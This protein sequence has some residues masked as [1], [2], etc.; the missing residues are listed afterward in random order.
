M[1]NAPDSRDDPLLPAVLARAA[2]RNNKTSRAAEAEQQA[3]NRAEAILKAES[4]VGLRRTPQE[5]EQAVNR[6]FV[7]GAYFHEYAKNTARALQAWRAALD[8]LPSEPTLLRPMLLN[9]IGYTLADEG[10]TPAEWNEALD[11]TR[12]ALALAPTDAMIRDS[13]GWALYRV[14]DTKAARRVLRQAADDLP[15]EPDAHYH[16]GVALAKLGLI[17][18]ARTEFARALRLRPDHEKAKTALAGLPAVPNEPS[19]A[20]SPAPAA[21]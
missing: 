7:A 14:G 8:L 12:R 15:G 13:Y 3:A 19:V 20:L 11:L 17:S 6:L 9:Q 2:R 16:L 1:Q 18:E 10:T 4:G 21:G 5:T